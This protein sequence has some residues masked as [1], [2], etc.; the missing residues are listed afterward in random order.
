MAP[1]RQDIHR[2]DRRGCGENLSVGKPVKR[3]EA[4]RSSIE[5]RMGIS[6]G[7]GW[8]ERAIKCWSKFRI[9]NIGGGAME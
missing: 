9:Y 6:G 8:I 5:A 7:I 4:K 1:Q 3:R 2:G